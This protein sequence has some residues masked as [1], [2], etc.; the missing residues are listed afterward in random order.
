MKKKLV[1][2]LLTAAMAMQDAEAVTARAVMQ[3]ARRQQ[4]VRRIVIRR[5]QIRWQI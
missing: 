5:Q 4:K 3:T 2:A 1:A